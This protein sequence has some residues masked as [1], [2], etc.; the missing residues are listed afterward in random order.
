MKL[1][2][3]EQETIINY[4]VAEQ[5]ASVYTADPNMIK[6]MDRLVTQFPDTF[7]TEQ[8]TEISKTYLV[9]KDYIKIRRPRNISDAQ[10]EQARAKMKQINLSGKN[11]VKRT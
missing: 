4:N 11:R 2:R 6:R 1:S 3:Y 7:K 9:P 8:E 5:K 10:K